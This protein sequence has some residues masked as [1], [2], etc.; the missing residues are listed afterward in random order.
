MIIV[1]CAILIISSILLAWTCT[2]G[3]WKVF[4]E[5]AEF[6]ASKCLTIPDTS[7]A[8]APAPEPEPPVLPP[9]T[10]TP[11]TPAPAPAPEP[12]PPGPPDSSGSSTNNNEDDV[13]GTTQ[14]DNSV[15]NAAGN[16]DGDNADTGA[17]TYVIEGYAIKN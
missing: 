15:A 13:T 3:T 6:E 16:A 9:P 4:G 14:D 1:L 7:P 8:P 12:A 11:P 10:P 17:S 5:D 2:G